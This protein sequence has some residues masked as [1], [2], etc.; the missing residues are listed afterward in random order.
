MNKLV[1][2]SV[3]SVLLLLVMLFQDKDGKGFLL[4]SGLFL[5][6][7]TLVLDQ[8]LIGSHRLRVLYYS[9]R[10]Y[11]VS[12]RLS[13]SYLYRVKIDEKYLLVKGSYSGG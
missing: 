5:A 2:Y 13:V 9:L 12:I 10:Y 7:A 3:S 11:R 4:S 1:L 6:L 8:L